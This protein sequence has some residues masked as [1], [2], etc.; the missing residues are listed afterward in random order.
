MCILLLFTTLFTLYLHF[1]CYLQCF[2]AFM[3]ILGA[4]DN[5]FQSSVQ[6]L[7]LFTMLFALHVHYCCYSECFLFFMCI[8]AAIFNAF[9]FSRAYA[10]LFTNV[11][12]SVFVFLLLFR[13]LAFMCIWVPFRFFSVFRCTLLLITMFFALESSF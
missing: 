5:V 3:C 4:I 8:F 9:C 6:F 2:S 13:M 7:M 10:L 1:C 12:H 11:F